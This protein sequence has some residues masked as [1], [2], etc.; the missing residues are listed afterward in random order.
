MRA[1]A[2]ALKSARLFAPPVL[3]L[4][5]LLWLEEPLEFVKSVARPV[6]RI[7][8]VSP[9]VTPGATESPLE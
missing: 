5:E 3:V 4:V 1:F 7:T 2:A 8:P 9:G 6:E